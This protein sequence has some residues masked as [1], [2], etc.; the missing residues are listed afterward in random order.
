MKINVG[1][2]VEVFNIR[3]RKNEIKK[4][5]RIEKIIQCIDE[6]ENNKII[7]VLSNYDKVESKDIKGIYKPITMED[8][9]NE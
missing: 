1:D 9:D 8:D 4:V 5:I 7:F 2:C 3:S 6:E